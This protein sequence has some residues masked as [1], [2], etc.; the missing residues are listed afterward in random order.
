MCKPG[1]FGVVV[2]THLDVVYFLMIN[3]RSNMP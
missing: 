3:T 1:L 2:A